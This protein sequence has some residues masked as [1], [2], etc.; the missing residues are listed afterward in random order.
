MQRKIKSDI[1]HDS[2]EVWPVAPLV[3]VIMFLWGLLGIEK[4]ATHSNTRFRSYTVE[5]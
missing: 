2:H 4:E 1:N 3:L 5:Q